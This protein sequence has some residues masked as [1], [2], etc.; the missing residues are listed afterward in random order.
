MGDLPA[1]GKF[2]HRVSVVIP[3]LNEARRGG[4][5]DITRLRRAWRWA[6]SH[7]RTRR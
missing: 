4:S 1:E 7:G 3:A 2:L 6:S 5:H